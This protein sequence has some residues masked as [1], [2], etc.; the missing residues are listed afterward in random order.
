MNSQSPRAGRPRLLDQ[1][2]AAIRT[3]HYSPRTEEAYVYWI[4]RFIFHNHLRHP[5]EMG[6][7][8]VRCFLSDL[9]TTG[10]VSASTQNQALNALVFLY[11]RILGKELEAI[12]EIERAKYPKRLP[13]VLS[14]DEVKAL[15]AAV[16]GIPHLVCRLLYGAGLRLL[17]GLRLRVKDIDFDRSEITVRDG[18]G[19]K[20]RVS[21]LPASCKELIRAHLV[22]VRAL[23]EEDLRRGLGRAPMP[24][25]LARKYPSADRQWAWQYP[26]PSVQP[27]CRPSDRSAPPAS[28]SRDRRSEGS[29]RRCPKSRHL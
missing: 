26:L 5:A 20:D 3:L 21:M 6:P 16:E 25:A 8:E 12:G 23:H 27:L 18:K 19:A 11:K 15:L 1:V 2:R 10:R 24:F 14:Q 7:D 29:G 22:W 17:E 13:V 9:A 4:R 28:P